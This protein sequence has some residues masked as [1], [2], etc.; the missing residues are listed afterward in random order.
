MTRSK[1]A[2]SD[3]SISL[4][5]GGQTIKSSAPSILEALVS[6]PVPKKIITKG[7]IA[8]SNGEKK[9]ELLLTPIKMKR[10]LYPIARFHTAKKL[11]ILIK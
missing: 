8:V 10:L 7:S 2:E 4:T 9:A 3:F 6:L 1:K 5:V 11:G